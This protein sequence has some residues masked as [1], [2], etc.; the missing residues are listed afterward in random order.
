MRCSVPKCGSAGAVQSFSVVLQC[1]HELPAGHVQTHPIGADKACHSMFLASTHLTGQ[2]EC[3]PL[4]HGKRV[5]GSNSRG[6]TAAAEPRQSAPIMCVQSL[7]HE[8]ACRPPCGPSPLT[9]LEVHLPPA[10]QRVP[11]A[12]G[13]HSLHGARSTRQSMRLSTTQR[14]QP[15][16]WDPASAG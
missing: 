7:C 10:L 16:K 6:T 1:Q 5:L 12:E 11:C 14:A 8:P 4:L 9:D 2:P 15:P 13:E 3:A